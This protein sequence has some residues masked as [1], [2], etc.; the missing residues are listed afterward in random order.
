MIRD[1]EMTGATV[2]LQRGPDQDATWHFKSGTKRESSPG[3][4]PDIVAL[5]AKDVRIMYYAPDRPPLDISI[6]ELQASLVRDEPVS[7]STKGK[8]RD[9]PLSIE[10]QG[11]TLAELLDPGKRWPLKG[12]L[13]TD[14]QSFDFE[15]Y[16]TDSS[17]V[18]WPRADNIFG[19][20]E[21]AQPA[22]PW[23]QHHAAVRPLSA[24]SECAQRG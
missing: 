5:H 20:A 1:I 14:I 17:D 23:P 12:T 11:G 24:E 13:D 6:D 10:L 18:E 22:V 2:Y 15:G 21:A 16:I 7:I 19:P 4:I 3:V 9:F 8:I